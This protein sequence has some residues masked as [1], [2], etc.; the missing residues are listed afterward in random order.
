MSIGTVFVN[1][2][3]VVWVVGLERIISPSDNT[4]AVGMKRLNCVIYRSY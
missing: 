3:V 1:K 4:W 2:H